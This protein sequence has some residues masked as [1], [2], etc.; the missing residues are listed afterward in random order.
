MVPGDHLVTG[1]GEVVI[2]PRNHATFVMQWNGKMIYF[3]PASTASYA[4]LPKADLILLTHN[5]SDH[6]STAS[7]DAVRGPGAV[8]I[9]PQTTYN[10]LTPAQRAIATVLGYGASMNVQGMAVEA[11]FAYNSYHSPL[12]FG[13]G[14]VLTIGG[15]RI[16]ISGDTSN[17]PEIRTLTNIDVAFICMNQPYTMTVAEATNVVRAIRPKVVYP[18]HYRDSNGATANASV[19]K[20]W[21]GT[22]LGIEVRLRSWY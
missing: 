12:G 19:F 20:Q 14:Y 16:Y 1:D 8:I 11:V 17:A 7:I 10:S 3:D 4:G 22:D 9:A 13:N 18:Y 6:F 2:Q 21:L 5:H 15:R